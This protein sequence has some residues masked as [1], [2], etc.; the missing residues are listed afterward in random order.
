MVITDLLQQI[1]K[2][3]LARMIETEMMAKPIEGVEEA[4][5]VC[6]EVAQRYM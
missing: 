6:G 4:E 5:V 3:N 2:E 1:D